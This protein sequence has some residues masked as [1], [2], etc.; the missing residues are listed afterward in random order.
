MKSLDDKI[1]EL[2][3]KMGWDREDS[4]HEVG[5]R[6]SAVQ[7]W[8]RECANLCPPVCTEF[9]RLFRDPGALL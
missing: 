9:A 7:R 5:V 6:V 3:P 4:A 2:Y 8:E 1:R